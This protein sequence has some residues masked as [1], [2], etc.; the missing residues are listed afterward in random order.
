ML[1][2]QI[3]PY[4]LCYNNI[5]EL[6]TKMKLTASILSTLLLSTSIV[7]GDLVCDAYDEER[8]DLSAD[9][10]GTAETQNGKCGMKCE[11]GINEKRRLLRSNA[12]QVMFTLSRDRQ[13]SKKEVDG[14]EVEFVDCTVDFQAVEYSKSLPFPEGW[15]EAYESADGGDDFYTLTTEFTIEVGDVAG[16]GTNCS[17]TGELEFELAVEENDD[18]T[19]TLVYDDQELGVSC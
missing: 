9:I 15:S 10:E 16:V 4:Q 3:K 8:R 12:R 5:E 13:L 17:V 2:S 18:D 14:V 6:L 1:W 7:M 19:E 11:W